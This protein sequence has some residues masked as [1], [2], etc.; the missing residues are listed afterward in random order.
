MLRGLW[1]RAIRGE[2]LWEAFLEEA[3]FEPSPSPPF[4]TVYVKKFT[5]TEKVKE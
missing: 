2:F 5:R 3:H 1:K 4:T